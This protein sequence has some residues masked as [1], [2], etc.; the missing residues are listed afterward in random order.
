MQISAKAKLRV[1]FERMQRRRSVPGA[2]GKNGVRPEIRRLCRP[3]ISGM[4][5]LAAGHRDIV[6]GQGLRRA[7]P[8]GTGDRGGVDRRDSRHLLGVAASSARGQKANCDKNEYAGCFHTG[9]VRTAD[10]VANHS[11]MNRAIL[12]RQ[13]AGTGAKRFVTYHERLT[14]GRWSPLGHFLIICVV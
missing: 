10:E 13:S 9:I 6:L 12:P 11:V 14:T 3:R 2:R 1:C 4:L 8:C 5:D 7:S